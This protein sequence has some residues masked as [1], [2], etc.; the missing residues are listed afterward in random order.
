[1]SHEAFVIE[2][3]KGALMALLLVLGIVAFVLVAARL[4]GIL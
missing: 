1:M 3:R 2:A 4:G